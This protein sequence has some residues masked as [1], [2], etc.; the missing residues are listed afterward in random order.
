LTNLSLECVERTVRAPGSSAKKKLIGKPSAS[1]QSPRLQIVVST[2][3]VGSVVAVLL[4]VI[5]RSTSTARLVRSWHDIRDEVLLMASGGFGVAAIWAAWR[6][7]VQPR[8]HAAM[9]AAEEAGFAQVANLAPMLIW[10]SGPDGL[11]TFANRRWCEFTG[12]AQLEALGDGWLS[13]VHPDD[14]ARCLTSM[15]H[16]VRTGNSASAEYRLKLASGDYRWVLDSAAPRIDDAGACVGLIG[17]VLDIT[18]RRAGEQTVREALA[19]HQDMLRREN[20]LLREL[21]HRVRNN[22]A[23]LLGLI[24]LYE[25]TRRGGPELGHAIRGKV[26]AMKEV[27]DLLSR[28]RGKPIELQSIVN[29]L[30]SEFVPTDRVDAVRV[31]GPTVEIPGPQAAALAMILQELFTNSRKHGAIG[32]AKGTLTIQWSQSEPVLNADPAL[33]RAFQLVWRE[34]GAGPAARADDEGRVGLRLIEGLAGSELRGSSSFEFGETGFVCT[35][36]LTL[37]SPVPESLAPRV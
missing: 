30:T 1:K 37:E 29:K 4:F 13:A 5:A 31:S 35:L 12:L 27:H 8:E 10:T 21:D 2:L 9:A 11:W 25:R 14:R 33:G 17:S 20:L 34:H 7:T 23:G 22:L 24:S 36:D 26:R 19:H 3:I 16:G 32:S 15:N 6:Y 18:D 28:G